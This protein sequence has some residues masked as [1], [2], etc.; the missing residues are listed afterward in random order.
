MGT[1]LNPSLLA[2]WGQGLGANKKTTGPQHGQRSAGRG[3]GSGVVWDKE[4]I[5]SSKVE[6]SDAETK[7]ERAGQGI[8]QGMGQFTPVLYMP[9]SPSFRDLVSLLQGCPV[10]PI[11][12]LPMSIL[13]AA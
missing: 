2:Q 12:A 11:E 6:F 10:K 1:E 8:A 4:A 13:P 7:R 9:E 5:S 3:M